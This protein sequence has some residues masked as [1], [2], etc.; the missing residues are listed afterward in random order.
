MARW[1]RRFI[2]VGVVATVVDVGLFV[3]LADAGWERATADIVA[4]LVASVVS[5]SLHRFVTFADEPT[6]RWVRYPSAFLVIVVLA[7][8]VD[9]IVVT[10]LDD[11]DSLPAKLLAV[12]AAATVRT[13]AYRLFLL[14]VVRSELEAPTGRGPVDSPTRLSV[15]VP[16]FREA[17]RIADTVETLRSDLTAALDGEVV[18]IIV[19]DD[20]SPDDTAQRAD[21]AQA[22]QVVRLVPNRGKGGAVRA[23]MQ[24][25]NG[26]V[27][28]FTD[29]D[30]AYEPRQI[31][32]LLEQ[33]EGGYD[34]AIGS[35]RH[36]AARQLVGRGIVRELGSR[37]VNLA[38]NLLLLGQYRDTQ[39][40]IKAFRRDV[41]QLVFSRARIDGFAFDIEV[42]H[43]IERYHLSLAE[44]PVTV[45]NSERSTVRIGRDTLRLFGDLFRIRTNARNGDYELRNDELDVLPSRSG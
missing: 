24:V 12:L 35:R 27:V 28:A 16:A 22:D 29:A 21:A 40:G 36:E 19:V 17:D 14:R 44:V 4:L 30:L 43:L 23:G 11:L 8:A 3:L 7:G 20:G 33:I 1:I 37:V 2:A 25:A 41:A 6:T 15:V 45:A 26:R 39:C 9:I 38:T 5:F 10:S 34:A 31:M 18:E 13:L 32:P 42:L